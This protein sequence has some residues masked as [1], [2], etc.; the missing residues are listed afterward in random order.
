MR[1]FN[2]SIQDIIS[3]AFNIEAGKEYSKNNK[4]VY[5]KNT[6]L[7]PVF[8]IDGVVTNIKSNMGFIFLPGSLVENFT[9]DFMKGITSME[10][11]FESLSGFNHLQTYS[12]LET[13]SDQYTLVKVKNRLELSAIGTNIPG[14][15]KRRIYINENNDKLERI[16]GTARFTWVIYS[17]E[18]FTNDL[19]N[20]LNR[21]IP[22]SCQLVSIMY[23]PFKIINLQDKKIYIDNLTFK[24]FYA[25]KNL[26]NICTYGEI[27][28]EFLEKYKNTENTSIMSL[29][30]DIN[31]YKNIPEFMPEWL[32]ENMISLCEKRKGAFEII[33]HLGKWNIFRNSIMFNYVH[34]D[35]LS[36]NV[37]IVKYED[38]IIDNIDKENNICANCNTPL[39]DDIYVLFKN[40]QSNIGKSY[41]A[42]CMHC[43]YNEDGTIC[44]NGYKIYSSTDILARTIYPVKVSQIIST[45]KT[46]AIVQEILLLSFSSMHM[47]YDDETNIFL[48]K[49]S[50]KN[51]IGWPYDLNSY[52]KYIND[53]PGKYNSYLTFPCNKIK[54]I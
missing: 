32:N 2:N 36:I 13:G 34:I 21:K 12:A 40:P 5:S 37:Y 18:Q 17:I 11:A 3:E 33:K 20:F 52:N 31:N 8:E 50:S 51:Y 27:N 42:I 29:I 48:L 44:R 38:I 26:L 10:S 16:V 25:C 6:S 23:D 39:Y 19:F 41:C 22:I 1:Y 30:R 53:N 35:I 4:L 43:Q 45:I 28:S 24:N 9:H 46:S 14:I 7:Y 15:I 47:E 54:H 49:S